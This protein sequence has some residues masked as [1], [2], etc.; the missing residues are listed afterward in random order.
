MSYINHAILF[1]LSGTR[2]DIL[3][4]YFRLLFSTTLYGWVFLFLFIMIRCVHVLNPDIW[5]I[6]MHALH[7]TTSLDSTVTLQEAVETSVVFG[8][9]RKPCRLSATS[10]L[11]S[12]LKII[13]FCL[14][15]Q[16]TPSYLLPLAVAMVKTF[17]LLDQ[18]G[19]FCF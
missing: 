2:G 5:L 15:H 7:D 1:F 14:H 19:C 11:A 18:Q 9:K 17:Y 3:L 13:I 4:P 8:N 12:S 6:L 10:D 16:M